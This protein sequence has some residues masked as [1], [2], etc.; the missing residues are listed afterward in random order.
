MLRFIL[1]CVIVIILQINCTVN[2]SLDILPVPLKLCSL[3]LVFRNR[4]REESEDHIVSVFYK[5]S[6]EMKTGN[7]WMFAHF[8]WRERNCGGQ[9]ITQTSPNVTCC[10]SWFAVYFTIQSATLLWFCFF[11]ERIK[12]NWISVMMFDYVANQIWLH[13]EVTRVRCED[14]PFHRYFPFQTLLLHF[15]ATAEKKIAKKKTTVTGFHTNGIF[16]GGGRVFGQSLPL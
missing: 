6:T 4:K 12:N 1:P 16:F 9:N 10:L 14:D 11:L 7:I 2:K 5:G 15:A 13:D 3:K 8:T